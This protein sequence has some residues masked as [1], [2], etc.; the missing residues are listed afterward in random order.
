MNRSAWIAVGLSVAW[1][2]GVPGY[3]A[4]DAADVLPGPL[5]YATPMPKAAPP[6]T[7]RPLA[8]RQ[9]IL[10]AGADGAPSVDAGQVSA[11]VTELVG[12]FT[13]PVKVSVLVTDGI[14]GEVL[15]AVERSTPLTP[16][17]SLKILTGV[18]ALHDLGAAHRLETK[19]VFADGTLTLVGG[20]DVYLAA[21]QGNGKEAS[22]YAGL[23]DLARASADKLR[24]DGITSVTVTLDDT[25]FP[26]SDWSHPDWSGASLSFV[27]RVQP[28]AIDAGRV[29]PGENEYLP[30]PALA[31]TQTFAEHLQAAGI[32][33]TGDV[34]R[35]P[36]P[37]QAKPVAAVYSAPLLDVVA[38]SMKKSDNTATEVEC[39]L[40]A[41][42]QGRSA[43]FADATAA[44]QE[45]LRG[46]GV[47]LAGIQMRD[48]SGLS[49]N[50]R[51]TATS[52][53]STL[54]LAQNS[55]VA[56]LRLFPSALAFATT[57]DGTLRNR[58]HD[59][60][61]VVRAKTGSLSTVSSLTGTVVTTAGR[62]VNF[63]VIVDGFP[64]GQLDTARLEIDAFIEELAAL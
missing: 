1:V 2:V 22:G 60:D 52:L 55:N 4:L 57:P 56:S 44:V 58:F 62:P 46:L 9:P 36:A 11:A 20:G 29:A 33:V 64:E 24:A 10:V 12:R 63:A 3:L 37:A 47:D 17:S 21:D 18:A 25:L 30:D 34:G 53:I 41:L 6:P 50:N 27:G 31:A 39:R 38:L 15:G 14:S 61:V 13:D 26:E 16:A 42:Q 32:T 51:L 40:V 35:A 49:D 7:P 28:L 43:T 54:Q 19:T 8:A 45:T 59:T 5:T 48:C 23:G